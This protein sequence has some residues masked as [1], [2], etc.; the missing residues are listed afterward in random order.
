MMKLFRAFVFTS[1]LALTA[2]LQV[3]EAKAQ[4]KS[5]R[6]ISPSFASNVVV[7][8]PDGRLSCAIFADSSSGLSYQISWNGRPVGGPGHIGL[9]LGGASQISPYE[10]G[11]LPIFGAISRGHIDEQYPFHGAK[12]IAHNNANIL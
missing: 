6:V 2:T 7:T 3:V 12:A 1:F 8:S 9:R 10:I 11:S 5:I 4:L